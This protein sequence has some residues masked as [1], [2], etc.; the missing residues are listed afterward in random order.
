MSVEDSIMARLIGR[1]KEFVVMTKNSILK[2]H[3][4]TTVDRFINKIEEFIVEGQYENAVK[5]LHIMKDPN[6]FVMRGV[7]AQTEGIL[8]TQRIE[9]N[10]RSDLERSMKADGS[11]GSLQ[12]AYDTLIQINTE[13]LS[14]QNQNDLIKKGISFWIFNEKDIFPNYEKRSLDGEVEYAK[15]EYNVWAVKFI[16]TYIMDY[17]IS[18]RKQGQV[19]LPECIIGA[20]LRVLSKSISVTEIVNIIYPQVYKHPFVYSQDSEKR[21]ICMGTATKGVKD[22]ISR[23]SSIL[24]LVEILFNEAEYILK[25]GYN[26]TNPNFIPAGKHLDHEIYDDFRVSKKASEDYWKKERARKKASIKIRRNG[27]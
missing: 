27:G 24:K 21:R 18:E 11:L 12:E 20:K 14:T 9:Q 17:Y 13:F 23:T 22:K 2:L 16:P 5:Y 1:N 3:T 6:L 8:P 10:I 25:Y 4:I 7:L 26:T 15:D 19:T